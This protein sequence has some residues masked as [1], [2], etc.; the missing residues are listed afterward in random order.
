MTVVA[1]IPAY[2]E[3][4]TIKSV[5]EATIP[6]VDK[7]IVVDDGSTDD[8][9]D[10][11]VEIATHVVRYNRNSGVGIALKNGIKKALQIGADWIITLDADGEHN[12]REI[13]Q[14]LNAAKQENADIVVGSRFL[15]NGEAVKMPFLKRSSNAISTLMFT[16]LYR[17][18]LTDSQSGF[19]VYK[20]RVFELVNYA[21]SGMLINTEILMASAKRGLKIKEVPIIS[22]S[23][24]RK[25]GN[26]QF[27]EIADYPILLVRGYGKKFPLEKQI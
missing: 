27:D 13:P 7:I 17:V 8:T 5:L 24:G 3:G 4:R 22:I 21:Q 2:N 15:R 19:R 12:P 14:L 26:H 11:A 23:S 9:Y 18:K 25:M 10:K 16:F 6:N 1:V 20:R